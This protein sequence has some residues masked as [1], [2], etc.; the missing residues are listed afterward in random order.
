MQHLAGS[1]AEKIPA[2]VLFATE[3]EPELRSAG[4]PG[5]D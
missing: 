1:Y 4:F 3:L 5:S 2:D